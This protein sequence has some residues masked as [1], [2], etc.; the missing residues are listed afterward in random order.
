MLT[1]CRLHI[2]TCGLKNRYYQRCECPVWV[3]GTTKAGNYVPTMR[4]RDS[5]RL[6][7]CS[8]ARTLKHN[9]MRERRTMINV[10]RSSGN[11]AARAACARCDAVHISARSSAM[12]QA[13]ATGGDRKRKGLR[14]KAGGRLRP[15]QAL[16]DAKSCLAV[17]PTQSNN[18]AIVGVAEAMVDRG[19]H[20]ITVASEHKA[21]G[22]FGMF[23][24]FRD[25]RIFSSWM[26]WQV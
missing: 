8:T 1:L 21:A 26:D 5:C 3:E 16:R 6:L 19:R 4:I 15:W 2:R 12:R 24:A 11:D 25:R 22:V 7:S 10:P 14:R 9:G 18:L 13:G 23:P 20:I 17:E